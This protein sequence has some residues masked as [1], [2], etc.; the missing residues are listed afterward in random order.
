[1]QRLGHVGT[2]VIHHHGLAGAGFLYAEVWGGPHLFQIARQEA[3]GEPEVDEAGHDGLHQRIVLR[4][5]LLHHRLSDFDG[6]AM[7]LL[8]GGQRAVAL[9]LA[10]VGPVGNRHPS[11]SG[12]IPGIGKGLLH[13]RRD[14]V[15]YFFHDYAFSLFSAIHAR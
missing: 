2:A 9:V 3:A 10:Q 12:V 4:V 7:V 5:Q 1:M 15:K 11:V 8:G 6:S 14:N 13:F